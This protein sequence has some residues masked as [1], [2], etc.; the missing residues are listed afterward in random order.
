[1]ATILRLQI[2]VKDGEETLDFPVKR[3]YNLGFTIRDA[4]KMQAH[5]DEVAKEGV[6]PPSTDRPPIIFP[7][8][9]WSTI[10]DTQVPVQY[11]KTSGEIEIVTLILEDEVYVG[12]GSDHT[13]RALEAINIPWSKQVA[14]NVL[15]PTIWRWSDVADHWDHIE[16]ECYVEEGG[17]RVLYQKAG[18]AEF[19]TPIEMRESLAGRIASVQDGGLVLFSGTV[20]SVDHR[21]S[22]SREWTI[23][24]I[25]P[26]LDR[27]IDHTYRIIVLDEELL[28]P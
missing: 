17:R 23:S 1:M 26:V 15:A 9:A 24:M 27:R 14:P 28:V 13:D 18:V 21:L 2:A 22:Y 25:D 11:S 8:S 3:V 5:L 20:V 7:I 6:P 12:V 19:W 10:T 16:M 4:A